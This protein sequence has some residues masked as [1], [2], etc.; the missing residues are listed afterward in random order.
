MVKLEYYLKFYNFTLD[1]NQ[2]KKFP[3]I[4]VTF[5]VSKNKNY[6]RVISIQFSIEILKQ[7]RLQIYANYIPWNRTFVFCQQILSLDNTCYNI[8]DY[9]LKILYILN[10]NKFFHNIVPKRSFFCLFLHEITFLL[11]KRD[12]LLH[13]NLGFNI[14]NDLNSV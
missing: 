14:M 5:K 3:I 4:N 10:F 8:F 2:E 11:H 6:C 12:F 9:N 7:L 1:A 13:E